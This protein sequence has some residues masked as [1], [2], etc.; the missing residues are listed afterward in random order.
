MIVTGLHHY[1][2]N[3]RSEKIDECV[4]FYTSVLNLRIGFRPPLDDRG[5]WLYAGE[6]ALLHLAI[7]DTE[8]LVPSPIVDRIA[9]ACVNLPVTIRRLEDLGIDYTTNHLPEI[10]QFQIFVRD[11]LGLGIEL[12]FACEKL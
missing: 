12:N 7:C 6:Q 8:D 1:A 4:S 2:L 10:D 9:F 3:A 5:F 11:P